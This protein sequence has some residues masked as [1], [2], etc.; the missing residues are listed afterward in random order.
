MYH[1]FI[2]LHNVFLSR[3]AEPINDVCTAE[4]YFNVNQIIF[5]TSK[6]YRAE[7]DMP[8]PVSNYFRPKAMVISLQLMQNGREKSGPL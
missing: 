5:T 6:T 2:A 4:V 1:L 8:W 7:A 3:P